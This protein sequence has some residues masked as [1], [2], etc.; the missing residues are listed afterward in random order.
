MLQA[1]VSNVHRNALYHFRMFVF[2]NAL[3]EKIAVTELMALLR[4][5]V[6][7]IL[8][9]GQM[10]GNGVGNPVVYVVIMV[11]TIISLWLL[12]NF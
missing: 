2:Q 7:M 5:M 4:F 11:R 9:M 6:A 8:I 1:F 3:T 12:C 10:L